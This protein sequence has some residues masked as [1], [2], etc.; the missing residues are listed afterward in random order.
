MILALIA[1]LAGAVAE[2]WLWR[3]KPWKT[4]YET[5]PHGDPE[6]WRKR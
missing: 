5:W 3:R 1:L 2:W 4:L 6:K